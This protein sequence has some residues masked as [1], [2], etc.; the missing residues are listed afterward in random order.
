MSQREANE[1]LAAWL[2]RVE[3]DQTH[4]NI[5]PKDAATLILLDNTSSSPKVLLGRRHAG[6]AFL[7]GKFVFPGGRIDRADF[8]APMVNPPHP[9]M[10][11]SLMRGM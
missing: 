1:N 4:P 6:H 2:T 11:T 7:P 5:R 3:R 9:R 8:A 10:E